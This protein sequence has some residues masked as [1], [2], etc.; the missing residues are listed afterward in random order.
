[1]KRH[2]AN[3]IK[4][5]LF[6]I[7]EKKYNPIVLCV[8]DDKMHFMAVDEALLNSENNTNIAEMS[9][10]KRLTIFLEYQQYTNCRSHMF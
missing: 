8:F 7:A 2:S 5:E 3:G 1:M 9:Y 4:E 6:F 10:N